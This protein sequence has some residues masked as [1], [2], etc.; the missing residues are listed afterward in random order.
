MTPFWIT[1]L[2]DAAVA[3]RPAVLV[4]VADVRGSAPREA[5]AK[6]VVTAHATHGTIGGGRLELECITGA[7]LMLQGGDSTSLRH[8]PLGPALGQCCGGAVA[9]LFEIVAPPAWRV[10]VFGAGHVGRAVVGLLAGLPCDVSWID[11][12]ASLFDDS[13][14]NVRCVSADPVATADT[15]PPGSHVLVMTHDHQLD[16]DLVAS[17]LAR[18]DLG[19]VGLIG[20][21]TKRARFASRLL[22]RG[23]DPARLVCPIG[24]PGAGGKLAAEIAISVV[25]QLLQFRDNVSVPPESVALPHAECS[26]D[27]GA[28]AGTIRA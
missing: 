20:S 6:M 11:G 19:S 10:A 22:A 13:P 17:L 27:C 25:A 2:H 12:R 15:L 16:F 3:A 28:C 5:G 18:R 26:S 21:E 23:L 1:A 4:T 7:R 8:F 24:V 9:V 14:A